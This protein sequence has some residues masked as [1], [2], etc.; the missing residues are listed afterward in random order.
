MNG[1]DEGSIPGRGK[2][3]FLLR[4]VQ[5]DIQ[6]QPASHP[7]ATLVSFPG[8]KLSEPESD[9][10]SPYIYVQYM[11]HKYRYCVMILILLLLNVYKQKIP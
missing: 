4:S 11:C 5:I 6:T 3:F 9:H 8:V 10:K 1:M 2:R 7:I